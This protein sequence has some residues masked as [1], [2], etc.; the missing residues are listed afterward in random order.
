M[1][2]ISLIDSF[3]ITHKP[4]PTTIPLRRGGEERRG[5][6]IVKRRGRKKDEGSESGWRGR[7]RGA[8]RGEEGE[9]RK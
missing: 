9:E 4:F 1:K 7:E 5:A 6:R 3:G 2:K 8:R